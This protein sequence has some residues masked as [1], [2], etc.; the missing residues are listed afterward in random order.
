MSNVMVEKKLC[1]V[2]QGKN[3]RGIP[4]RGGSAHMGNQINGLSLYT[5]RNV[6]YH[7]SFMALTYYINNMAHTG[8]CLR[9]CSGSMRQQG[10]ALTLQPI[11][12]PCPAPVRAR[13]IP[14]FVP[15]E[16]RVI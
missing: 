16:W 3:H 6:S 1:L 13:C 9:P 5:I 8:S 2:E 15:P 7:I 10:I 4:P 11:D 14:P 12:S